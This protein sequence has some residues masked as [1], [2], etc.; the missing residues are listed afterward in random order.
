MR[1][2]RINVKVETFKSKIFFQQNAWI[3]Y[4]RRGWEVKTIFHRL[5]QE[6]LKYDLEKDKEK[7]FSCFH[8][9]KS[10]RLQSIKAVEKTTFSFPS[11]QF[12]S[13]QLS[14]S[15]VSNSLWPHRLQHAPCPS[16]NH[17]VD[18]NSC[19][20]SLWCHPT[21]S[22]SVSPFSSCLQSFQVSGYFP[23]SQFFASDSQSIGVSHSTSVLSM[24]LR[25]DLLS[26]GPDPKV[27][28]WSPFSP[29]DSQESSSTPQFKSINSS[30]LS[31]LYSPTLTSIHDYWKNDSFD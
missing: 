15:V 8:S 13:V 20:L 27:Q 12:S 14:H 2:S 5:A 26:G 6:G 31:F 24:T 21:I 19:T 10:W 11:I 1:V 18:P 16:P 9:K 22:S 29:R 4:S 23:V 25:T 3:F 30:A 28:L 7:P 17:G